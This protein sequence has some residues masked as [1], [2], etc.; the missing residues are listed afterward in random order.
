[1]ITVES[2]INRNEKPTLKTRF[3]SKEPT[4]IINKFTGEF[5]GKKS[6]DVQK[7]MYSLQ[8][9]IIDFENEMMRR[10]WRSADVIVIPSKLEEEFNQLDCV[11]FKPFISAF[12]ATNKI[13]LEDAEPFGKLGITDVFTSDAIPEDL[14]LI[15]VVGNGLTYVKN[16]DGID[17]SVSTKPYDQK[18][19]VA[20]WGFIKIV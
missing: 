3:L 11:S 8:E 18:G 1:M 17:V 19:N 5:E 6:K 10:T 16:N 12:D 4:S 20:F 13:H 9:S 15:G 14:I 7:F 2:V